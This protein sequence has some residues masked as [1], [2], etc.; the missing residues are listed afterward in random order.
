M[1]RIS[2]GPFFFAGS[3]IVANDNFL[4]T[5]L[6]LGYRRIAS[7]SKARPAGSDRT[8]PD[9]FRWM[10]GP[11]GFKVHAPDSRISGRAKKLRV[12]VRRG[13]LVETI[14]SDPVA[15]SGPPRLE[16]GNEISAHAPKAEQE[17]R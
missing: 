3:K 13:Q 4:L 14:A 9:R 10:R 11:I 7:D 16:D 2:G 12:I 8:A 6:F 1:S 17:K 15:S 5:A